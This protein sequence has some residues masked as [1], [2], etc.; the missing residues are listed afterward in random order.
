[1]AGVVLIGLGRRGSARG[2]G[3]GDR[4]SFQGEGRAVDGVVAR[5]NRR[6]AL[7]DRSWSTEPRESLGNRGPIFAGLSGREAE[8]AAIGRGDEVGA[9]RLEHPEG[10]EG[11]GDGDLL[12]GLERP[13]HMVEHGCGDAVI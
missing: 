10:H 1:M 13:E 8:V 4:V 5:V 12:G 6:A 2:A 11:L 7:S 9:S 3:I